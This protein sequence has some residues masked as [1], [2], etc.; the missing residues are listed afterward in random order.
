MPDDIIADARERLRQSD[1]DSHDNRKAAAEDIR[2]S[3]LADQWPEEV[4]NLREEEGR[5]CLTI[6]RL[7]AFIRQVVNDARQAKPGLEVHPIDNGADEKT[8][9][10]IGGILRS[11]ERN[12]NA[13]VAYDTAIDSSVTGGF[14][15]FQLA[16]DYAHDETFDLEAKIERILDPLSVHWDTSSMA[17]DAADWTYAFISKQLTDEQFESSYPNADKVEFEAAESEDRR[18]WMGEEDDRTRVA[19]YWLREEAKRKLLLLSGPL[20]PDGSRAIRE[21]DFEGETKALAEALGIEV[22]REREVTYHKV[23]R[24]IISGVEVLE[25]EDWPG[26]TIP[27]CPVWGEEVMSDGYRWFRSLVRDAR[28][29][30]AMFNF[31]R[32]AT[33][34]LVALAP[35]APWVGQQGFTKGME[36]RWEQANT[37]SYAYLEYANGTAPPVRQ[38]FAGVPAGALQEALNASDDLK[39]IM[40]IFDPA[41]GARSNETS[42]KAILARQRESDVSNFHFIDNLARAMGYAGKVLVEIIPHVYSARETVRILGED[43]KEEVVRL[44][45]PQ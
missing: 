28:D 40:G 29:P 6:N 21:D 24:R 37:R 33:T 16:I 41:L 20:S 42:G 9:H 35:K 23:K 7:P 12:S 44:Q 4:K 26:S 8:A 18:L 2:F 36:D 38:P 19:E 10:V 30:Q 25:E 32:T 22:L 34:E 17:F 43:M 14:G 45:W 5:P 31:W 39:S 27:I 1:E 11:I 15:F 3:R 13:S